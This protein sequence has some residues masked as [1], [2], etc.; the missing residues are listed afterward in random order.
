MLVVVTGKKRS[1]KDTLGDYLVDTYGCAKARPL[2]VFKEA[3][4]SW[5]D[6]DERH[7]NGELKEVVD[8]RWGFSPRRLMQVFGTELMKYDLGDRLPQY[9]ET[10]A[11]DI[12]VQS[13][14]I[15][16]LKQDRNRDYVLTDMR[17]PNEQDRIKDELKDEVVFVKTI[18]DRSP[19]DEHESESY[20]D[21][22]TAD[23]SIVNNGWD[24]YKEYY[25]NIDS[26]MDNIKW[27]R[28]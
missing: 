18:S 1:G 23:F 14:L 21:Q 26:L 11:Y 5:F 12:W 25:T 22:L 19:Q 15:W 7:M 9:R 17:F 6:W 2:A 20:F 28:G 4:T 27:L 8:E 10:C 13:F 24:T 3:F 16:Y